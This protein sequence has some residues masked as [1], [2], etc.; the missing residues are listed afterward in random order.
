M[1]RLVPLPFFLAV[2]LA[3]ACDSSTP[4]PG[5]VR[6]ANLIPDGVPLDVCIK[7]DSASAFGTP[8]VGGGGLSYPQLSTRSAFDA[9]TYSVRIVQAGNP[10]S[11]SYSNL[12]DISASIS[13]DNPQ[14]LVLAGRFTGTGN[15]TVGVKVIGDRI[16]AAASGTVL[17]RAM[18]AALGSNPQDVGI[19]AS[20]LFTPFATNLAFGAV[21]DY[22]QVNGITPG[23][24]TVTAPLASRDTGSGPVWAQGTFSNLSDTGVYTVFVIGIPGQSGTP[25]PSMLLCSE[26]G[27]NCSQNP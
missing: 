14:T 4:G 8:L 3:L 24:P 17:L 21:S 6:V 18:N 15:P 2:V 7:P 11:N 13:A 12:G 1:S 9:G 20:Q 5:Q 16:A 25:R 10:C 19:V 27:V 22:Q 26:A 23:S